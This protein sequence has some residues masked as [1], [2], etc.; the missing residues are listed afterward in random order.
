MSAI[1]KIKVNVKTSKLENAGTD[2]DIFFAIAGREFKLDSSAD[3]FQKDSDRTYILGKKTAGE[4]GTSVLNAAEND[5]HTHFILDTDDLDRFPVWIRFEPLTSSDW[6][7]DSVIATVN[8][9]RNEVRY[10]VLDGT[11][12]LW[13]GQNSG[14]Y[15]FLKK[16]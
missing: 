10:H 14:K 1:N 6:N 2:G 9:G 11:G 8:P 4:S 7:L 13:L 3:D 12:D 15:C 5:P 16:A